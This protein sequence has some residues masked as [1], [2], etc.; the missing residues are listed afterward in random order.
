MRWWLQS[1]GMLV[2]NHVEDVYER[3]PELMFVPNARS[4]RHRSSQL[5]AKAESADFTDLQFDGAVFTHP[6]RRHVFAGPRDASCRIQVPLVQ[7]AR[8]REAAAFSA[9]VH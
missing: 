6:D 2:F 9:P 4:F 5:E 1:T 7:V 3:Q 8:P